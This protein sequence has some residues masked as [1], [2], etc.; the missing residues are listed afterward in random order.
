[1]ILPEEFHAVSHELGVPL[2][3]VEKDYVMGWVLWGI[4]TR[5]PLA[6]QL[7]LKGGNCLRK[8]YYSDTRFSDDLDFTA[9]SMPTEREF[10]DALVEVCHDLIATAG[11][12]FQV[13]MTRVEEK[14]TPDPDAKAID[15]RIYF[16]GL[17][18]DA[19]LTMRLKFDVSDYEV[20]TLP[21]ERRPLLH[22]YSDQDDCA[23]SVTAY[24]L[25]EILAEKLR[26][27]IQR[28]RARDL[29]DAVKIIR[30]HG[31]HIQKRRILD[32]FLR[33]TLFKGFPRAGRDEL[34]VEE[35]FETVEQHWLNTIV[36]A[37]ASLI[38]AANAITLFTEFVEALF[39]TAAL[40]AGGYSGGAGSFS[41]APYRRFATGL[42][43]SIIAAGRN[44]ETVFMRY[45]GKER[46]IEPYC[47]RYKIRKSD[48]TGHEYFFGYDRTSGLTIKSFFVNQIESVR[49]AGRV[50][51]PRYVVEF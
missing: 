15:G 31:A 32:A 18:G 27:W 51:Q 34:L 14:A 6:E 5:S 1:M 17:A 23:V 50:F 33:K 25:E 3:H 41:T 10:E 22:I 4:Y 47:F 12:P 9:L 11:I 39:S 30:E 28:T 49:P 40:A 26:S 2:A 13:D 29:F 19:S 37:P 8:A 48:H 20:L 21:T 7:V 24:S 45:K 43:E 16:S 38:V 44:R 42:R 46:E 35:K 36:C